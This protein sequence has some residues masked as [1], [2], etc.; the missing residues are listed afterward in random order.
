ML[1]ERKVM[2]NENENENQVDE[3]VDVPG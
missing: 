1:N 3:R 2:I